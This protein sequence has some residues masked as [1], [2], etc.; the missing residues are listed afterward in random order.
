MA[1][2]AA[3]ENTACEQAP[4]EITAFFDLSAD[5]WQLQHVWPALTPDEQAAWRAELAREFACHG[6]H[7]RDTDCS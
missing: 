2:D 4:F 5:P 1:T 3:H 6:H 7:G